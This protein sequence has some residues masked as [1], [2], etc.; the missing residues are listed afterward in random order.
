MASDFAARAEFI[1]PRR[2]GADHCGG[3]GPGPRQHALG[4]SLYLL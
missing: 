3:D 2:R 4:Y 1:P